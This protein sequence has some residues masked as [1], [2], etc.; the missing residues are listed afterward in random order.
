MVV[1][2]ESHSSVA[3]ITDVRRRFMCRDGFDLFQAVF[4]EQTPDVLHAWLQQHM[5]GKG[6][7]PADKHYLICS[8]VQEIA[9]SDR[10][11]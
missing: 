9:S 10:F 1:H 4:P 6:G 8:A 11:R 5:A 7:S 2:L 3:A